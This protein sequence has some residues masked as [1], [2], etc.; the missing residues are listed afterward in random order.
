MSRRFV[1]GY[2]CEFERSNPDGILLGICTRPPSSFQLFQRM[3]ATLVTPHGALRTARGNTTGTALR[4]ARSVK[5]NLSAV[6]WVLPLQA[7]CRRP[8][9][10]RSL[11]VVWQLALSRSGAAP[12]SAAYAQHCGAL[13][14][15]LCSANCPNVLCRP[16]V[17][18][19]LSMAPPTLTA[20]RHFS[21]KFSLN[22]PCPTT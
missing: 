12:A 8:R 17:F 18:V 13:M 7:L 19:F 16:A 11:E 15:F 6:Q 9:A 10:R 3:F 5:A 21:G 14:A 22:H 20:I 2:P 4:P 1:H